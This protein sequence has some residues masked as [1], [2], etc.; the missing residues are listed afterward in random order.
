MAVGIRYEIRQIDDYGAGK[1]INRIINCS[2][3]ALALRSERDK[4]VHLSGSNRTMALCP[5]TLDA[6]KLDIG[7]D[8]ISGLHNFPLLNHRHMGT[9][10][11]RGCPEYRI[12]CNKIIG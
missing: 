5:L 7:H 6:V 12:E 10:N 4:L 2:V 8:S 3:K 11:Q 9:E 1:R